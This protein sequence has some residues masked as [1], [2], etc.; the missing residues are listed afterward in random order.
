VE[1]WI[2]VTPDGAVTF[3]D[4]DGE[5]ENGGSWSGCNGP[6]QRTCTLVTHLI[7]VRHYSEDRNSGVGVGIGI[8][9]GL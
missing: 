1:A 3:Y 7:A 5:R 9:I 8:G 6:A 4:S 2:A